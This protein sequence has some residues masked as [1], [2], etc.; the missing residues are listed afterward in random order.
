VKTSLLKNSNLL[1]PL[2]LCSSNLQFNSANKVIIYAS[3][4]S[5]DM[6]LSFYLLQVLCLF[7]AVA[8]Y[9]L[10]ERKVMAA[11]QRRKGP[12]VVGFWGLLQAIA[13]AAKLIF[14]E[15]SLPKYA[16]NALYSQGPYLMFVVSFVN[17]MVIPFG[18]LTAHPTELSLIFFYA[19]NSLSVFGLVLSG[20]ASNSK[21][22]F[23]GALRSSAQMISYEV[24]LGFIFLIVGA[25]AGS[26]N[27][28]EICL[29]QKSISFAFPLFPIFLIFL[30][31][32]LAETNRIP[33]DLPEAE[34]ELVAGYNTE[35]SSMGFT[36]FFL[37]EYSNMLL[38]SFLIVIC[39]LKGWVGLFGQ[40]GYFFKVTF[41]AFF[42]V[43]IRATLPRYRYDQLMLLGWKTFLPI[44]ISYYFFI[45]SV[46]FFFKA[47][48][49]HLL[50]YEVLYHRFYWNGWDDLLDLYDQS[51]KLKGS[52]WSES[53]D[54]G[55]A[56]K[57][58]ELAFCK[59]VYKQI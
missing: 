17:W 58:A 59:S 47:F 21:Y 55:N 18:Y 35:Y 40:L 29:A 25:F 30:I 2:L 6:P 50:S 4:I 48:P 57:K 52:P 56:A 24:S 7:L 33:F 49:V 12:N 15:Y 39:F 45:I 8:F 26:Y 22:A 20:W 11:I 5:V 31:T 54:R 32:A 28:V 13:D 34:A 53:V 1:F 19:I 42:F 43:W 14:K 41:L 37:A 3:F 51:E 16:E 10:G 9:T 27:L 36:L 46:L 23:L 44:V 38:M